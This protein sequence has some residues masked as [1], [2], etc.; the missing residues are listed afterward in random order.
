M[1]RFQV[2]Q[3]QK[4]KYALLENFAF[5]LI[6]RSHLSNVETG[7]EWEGEIVRFIKDRK[8]KNVPVVIPK[9]RIERIEIKNGKVYL[10][11]GIRPIKEIEPEIEYTSDWKEIFAYNDFG[12]EEYLVKIVSYNGKILERK[13]ENKIE[14]WYYDLRSK[15]ISKEIRNRLENL[16]PRWIENLRKWI[17]EERPNPEE[18]KKYISQKVEKIIKKTEEEVR[19]LKEELNNLTREK[20]EALNDLK[21]ELKEKGIEYEDVE[22]IEYKRGVEKRTSSEYVRIKLKNGKEIYS[23]RTYQLSFSY[24]SYIEYDFPFARES[25][26]EINETLKDEE[27]ENFYTLYSIYSSYRHFKELEKEIEKIQKELEEK[28]K[29]LKEF[30]GRKLIFKE[31]LGYVYAEWGNDSLVYD[32]DIYY[33]EDLPFVYKAVLLKDFKTLERIKRILEEQV[34]SY[35]PR[36]KVIMPE[37]LES[38]F[39]RKGFEIKKVEGIL[40]PDSGI[41]VLTDKG[42]FLLE[43][44]GKFWQV[45]KIQHQG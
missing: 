23:L 25:E 8:G 43:Y 21:Q 44:N 33:W 22:K 18:A 3:N 19:K 10:Y 45:F 40:S 6:D 31:I 12:Y 27:G 32:K 38:F 17:N 35:T 13:I 30:K 5:A 1:L 9:R 7:E 11:S 42:E 34:S 24:G 28:E 37:A 16:F 36:W 20:E 26:K 14:Y 41:K 4:G 15:N 2:R 29:E 39:K